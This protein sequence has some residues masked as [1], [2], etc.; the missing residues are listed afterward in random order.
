MSCLKVDGVNGKSGNGKAD[1]PQKLSNFS[2]VIL[3]QD[4]C[5]P[6]SVATDSQFAPAQGEQ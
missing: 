2:Y 1:E 3:S 4:S 5:R 6:L